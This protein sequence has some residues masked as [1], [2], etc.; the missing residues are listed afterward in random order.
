MKKGFTF[1]RQSIEELY[2]L[3]DHIE[4]KNSDQQAKLGLPEKVIDKVILV[5]QQLH[6]IL[7]K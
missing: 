1:S 3:F 2:D 4:P 5:R 6:D 7:Y